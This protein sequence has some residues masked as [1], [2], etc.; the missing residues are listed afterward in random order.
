MQLLLECAEVYQILD[1]MSSFTRHWSHLTLALAA[2][3]YPALVEFNTRH[4]RTLLTLAERSLEAGMA[5]GGDGGN[6]SS[7]GRGTQAAARTQAQHVEVAAQVFTC[8]TRCLDGGPRAK[9]SS[10]GA[11]SYEAK[12]ETLPC[13]AGAFASTGTSANLHVGCSMLLWGIQCVLLT[14][15]AQTMCVSQ[16]HGVDITPTAPSSSAPLWASARTYCIEQLWLRPLS[17]L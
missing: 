11:G 10:A 8:L 7:G 3:P 16:C 14:Q 15:E 1:G 4:G 6:S 5:A 2:C 12:G 9:V 17:T 13:M